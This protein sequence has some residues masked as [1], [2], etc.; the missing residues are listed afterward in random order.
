MDEQIDPPARAKQ[1]SRRLVAEALL[2]N[3]P[4]SR[5]DLARTTGLSKQTMSLVIAELERAGWVQAVGVAT[6]GIGRNAVNYEVARDAAY[7][8]GV[9]VGG[10]KVIAAIADLLGK[11]VAEAAE[12]TDP[13]GG[14]HVLR[15][16][17]SLSDR[18][19]LENGLDASRIRSVVVGT[20]GVVDPANGALSLIPNI[21]GL[22]EISVT[23]TLAE[24][25]GQEVAI[26]N[27]VNLAV[28]GEVWQGCA[29]GCQNAAFLALGTG[30]GLGLIVNG[31]LVRGSAGAAGE[32]AYLPIGA[33]THS[34]DAL[35][36]GAFE[37]E[38]GA[39]GI[40][41]RYRAIG[42]KPVA[43]VQH[44]FAAL[45]ARDEAASLVLDATAETIALA[46]A[47]LQ[48]ILDAE[49]VILGGGIGIRPELVT[50]VQK[51][52]R[53]VFAREV[54]IRASALGARASLVGAVSLAVRRLHSD[55]FGIS[56]APSE[57]TFPAAKRARA[58]E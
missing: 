31:K 44:V 49:L 58:A 10:T 47:A 12:P 22:S 19:A 41:R 1:F 56:D 50:R 7:S 33:Q 26:E 14:R 30:V 53:A 6:G 29:R 42:S 18:L 32:I 43:T 37:L 3:A 17:R 52:M 20:P 27:D 21:S 57:V 54:T 28:L 46:I 11:I 51:R 15:Q 48:S 40:L 55:Q 35:A 39:A 24:H 9:D 13:R 16:I 4:V 23:R 36:V 38:V 5:A 2:R 45:A 8:L 25:Y 34:S